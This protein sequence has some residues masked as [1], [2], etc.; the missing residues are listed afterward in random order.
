[1]SSCQANTLSKSYVELKAKLTRV[2]AST[3]VEEAP[4][5]RMATDHDE[6]LEPKVGKTRAPQSRQEDGEEDEDDMKYFKRLAS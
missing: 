3:D 1:M 4:V 5:T 2:L 6:E